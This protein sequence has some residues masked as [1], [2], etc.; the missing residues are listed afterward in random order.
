MNSKLKAVLLIAAAAVVGVGAA[1]VTAQAVPS[2]T[3]LLTHVEALRKCDTRDAFQ[4]PIGPIK[5]GFAITICGPPTAAALKLNLTV[6]QPQSAGYLTVYPGNGLPN[7]TSSLNFAAGQ[8]IANYTEADTGGTGC[9][10]IASPLAVT[11]IIVD[12][13]GYLSTT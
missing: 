6:D 1:Q 4:C 2:S 8:T 3:P 7:A 13:V 12:Q 9:V 10:R 5:P 11:Q